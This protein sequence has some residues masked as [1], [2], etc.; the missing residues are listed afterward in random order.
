MRKSLVAASLVAL[1]L[2]TATA[3]KAQALKDV[4]IGA[5]LALTGPMAIYALGDAF[6][7]RL[8]VKEVEEDGGF[9]VNGVKHRFV[10]KEEDTGSRA[11]QAVSA[12]QK[13]LS[14]PSI[15]VIIGPSTTGDWIPAWG[16]LSKADVIN[17]SW[18]TAALPY[19]GTPE[20]K[21]LFFPNLGIKAPI[22]GAID[23]AV[24]RWKPKTAA[25]LL[26]AD[27]VG[28]AVG[29]L[30][31]AK[32]A[33]DSVKIVYDNTFA[34]SSRDFSAQ[35][36]P[37]KALKPD[38]LVSGYFDD[39]MSTVIRQAVE[40]GAARRFVGMRGV[41]ESAGQPMGNKI[42][43]LIFPIVSRDPSQPELQAYVRSFEKHFGKKPDRQMSNGIGFHDSV[44]MLAAAMQAAGTTTDV[45]KITAA[46]KTIKTYPHPTLGLKFQ[47]NGIAHHVQEIGI[48]D[49][50]SGK[51]SFTRYQE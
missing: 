3:A 46:L 5:V 22:E 34:T 17:F 20:G 45:K 36:T 27:A 19:L 28:Q 8:A 33:K 12:T 14:D 18:A 1:S 49:G 29:P 21:N 43:G 2:I 26:P 30:I 35:L 6:S 15:K 47:A 4:P 41:T 40:L 16:L 10:L 31:R 23:V 48:L 9:T 13:L 25:L 50:T 51:V 7:I 44:W 11:T 39:I 42:D 32:L 38:L 24:K 37:I